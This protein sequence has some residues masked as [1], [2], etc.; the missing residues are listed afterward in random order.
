M[1]TEMRPFLKELV[2]LPDLPS[3]GQPVRDRIRRE[4]EPLVN[5]IRISRLGN[6]HGV[7]YG[8]G[9]SPRCQV[10]VVTH[11]DAP[12]MLVSEIAEGFLRLQGTGGLD[13]RVLVG[14]PVVVHGHRDLLGTIVA[15]PDLGLSP[16]RK[17]TPPRA[18]LLVD[19][20]LPS[21]QVTRYVRSG[22]MIS[23]ALAPVDL[24]EDRLACQSLSSRACI[25]ALT[26]CLVELQ[27]RHHL[28][29]IAAVVTT[30]EGERYGAAPTS[31]YVL[32]PDVAIALGAADDQVPATS[33]GQGLTLGNGPANGWGPSIHPG[34]HREIQRAA[35]REG[36]QLEDEIMPLDSRTVVERL[37]TVGDGIPT[38][39]MNIP[40]RYLGTSVEVVALSD[41]RRTGRVLASLVSGL[42]P[43][44]REA[45]SWDCADDS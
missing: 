23:L 32:Q 41:I 45:L 37:Q 7:K 22:D 44:F 20:G 36:L 13:P 42:K 25:V 19:V 31:A 11:L 30:H 10:L 2:T 17:G 16:A 8:S 18:N 33:E 6:L 38:G 5:E 40:L 24:G 14:L 15:G 26:V 43:D 39:A 9:P 12:R 34:I 1:H 35:E 29:D 27:E 21:A 3:H 28:W 4:W